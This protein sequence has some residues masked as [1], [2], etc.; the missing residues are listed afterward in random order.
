VAVGRS[1]SGIFVKALRGSLR[2]LNASRTKR[3]HWPRVCQ[4]SVNEMNNWNDLI[5]NIYFAMVRS[6]VNNNYISWI[7]SI[8]QCESGCTRFHIDFIRTSN[9]EMQTIQVQ[10]WQYNSKHRMLTNEV[11]KRV[12]EC[13]IVRMPIRWRLLWIPVV[14]FFNTQSGQISVVASLGCNQGLVDW[15]DTTNVGLLP[16]WCPLEEEIIYIII[17]AKYSIV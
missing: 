16:I 12:I 6:V 8:S 11:M 9:G 13:H 2:I 4:G 5:S 15:V 17:F 1:K 3:K 7:D 10:Y 14:P